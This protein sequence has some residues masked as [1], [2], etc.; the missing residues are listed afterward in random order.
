MAR[1]NHVI[2]LRGARASLKLHIKGGILNKIQDAE[3]KDKKVLLRVDFNVP[4][5]WLTA[6]GSQPTAEIEGDKRI[7][8][9]IP[10]I[11]FLIDGGV[12]KIT[13]MSHLGK[14]DGKKDNKYSLLPVANR[15]AK[16]L[17]IDFEFKDF[18]DFYKLN[19]SIT[20][21]ENLR[22]N[23][24]EEEN[25]S[26]FAKILASDNDIFVQDAFGTC[27]RAHASTSMV[28]ELLPAYAGLL[29]QKEV[30]SLDKILVHAE[31]PFTIILGGA[32]IGDKLPVV[33]NLMD[34]TDN[35]LMG[36]AIANTFLAARRHYLGKSLVEPDEFRNANIVWQRLMDD[37]D[38]SLFLPKDLIVSLSIKQPEGFKIVKVSQ[39]LEPNF[40]EFAS[41][42]I[43]PETVENYIDVIKKS[44]TIF[45]NGNMGISEVKEFSTGTIGIAKAISEFD[46]SAVIGG[47]DT[48]TAVEKFE[49]KNDNVFLSTGGGATLEYLAGKILPGL[50]ALE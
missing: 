32:K 8:E 27:H 35:F 11:K 37:P 39:L 46:G 14:P 44:K 4:V 25:D 17:K 28:A 48:V 45:W 21:L 31:K 49:K 1:Q 13:I 9:A 7:R 16:L 47:G 2:F 15:L 5:K 18:A 50:K 38:K 10:T 6:D 40:E 22:F 23:P 41:V 34:K 29:V 30:E 20:L 43:G 12:Q 24:G 36:G 42:D 3:I 33:K 26:K 19:D